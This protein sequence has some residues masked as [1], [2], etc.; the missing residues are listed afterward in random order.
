MNIVAL[1]ECGKDRRC[2]YTDG[3]AEDLRLQDLRRLAK[4]ANRNKVH[5]EEDEPVGLTV[6]PTSVVLPHGVAK[7]PEAQVD[8]TN[9]AANKEAPT[10]KKTEET[11]AQQVAA[12]QVQQS[13]QPQQQQEAA[14]TR[15]VDFDYAIAFLMNVKNRFVDQPQTYRTFIEAMRVHQVEQHPIDEILEPVNS[16][17]AEHPDL[18]QEFTQFLSDSAKKLWSK[19]VTEAK[20]KELMDAEPTE[21][22]QASKTS[23]KPADK[24]ETPTRVYF[25]ANESP[26]TYC[27]DKLVPAAIDNNMLMRLDSISRGSEEE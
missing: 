16:L 22:P 8:K 1:L 17:L 23:G 19:V 25:Q 27:S 7:D 24:T 18:L 13:Q 14:S 2:V 9:A 12:A 21:K 10:D 6:V 26:A 3:D 11:T 15:V 5:Q 4:F 20:A